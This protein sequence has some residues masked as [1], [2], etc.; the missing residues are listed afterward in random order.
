MLDV[1]L[2]DTSL[3]LGV[4]TLAVAVAVAVPVGIVRTV[5][6]VLEERQTRRL[7]RRL[8]NDA[9]QRLSESMTRLAEANAEWQ[10]ASAAKPHVRNHYTARRS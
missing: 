5:R 4:G 10:L 2:I 1:D 3:I 7:S 8:V 9:E 6:R